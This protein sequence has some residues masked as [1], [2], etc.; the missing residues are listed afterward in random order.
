MGYPRGI[1]SGRKIRLNSE[2][3]KEKQESI[4]KEQV[5]EGWMENY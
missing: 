2:Y 1:L 4:A 5:G 3:N